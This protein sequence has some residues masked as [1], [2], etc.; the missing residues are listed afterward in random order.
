MSGWDDINKTAVNKEEAE[1]AQ[2]KALQAAAELAQAYS[3]CFNTKDGERVMTDLTNRFIMSNDMALDVK[4]PEYEAGYHNG[5]SGVIK[6]IIHQ[7][8]QARNL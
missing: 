8:T 7:L 1:L 5:E 6:L 4:N 2:K 3:R